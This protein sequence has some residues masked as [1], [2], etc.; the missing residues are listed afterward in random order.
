MK[1]QGCVSGLTHWGCQHGCMIRALPNDVAA[2]LR[3]GLLRDLPA[4]PHATFA[5]TAHTHMASTLL[6]GSLLMV[7]PYSLPAQ[8]GEQKCEEVRGAHVLCPAP[9][10]PSGRSARS[11][12]SLSAGRSPPR[13]PSAPSL[14]MFSSPPLPC[15]IPQPSTSLRPSCADWVHK[16]LSHVPSTPSICRS[17]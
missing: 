17:Y 16:P 2:V 6:Q 10:W 1:E 12:R 14:C 5:V 15:S 4:L 9:G 11:L 3:E 7:T 13:S 8:S